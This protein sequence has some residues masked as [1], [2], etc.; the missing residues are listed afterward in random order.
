MKNLCFQDEELFHSLH[1][2]GIKKQ[3]AGEVLL[4]HLEYGKKFKEEIER[5]ALAKTSVR[6]CGGKIGWGLF[7]EEALKNG[8]FVGEYTGNV[9]KNDDHLS[10]NNYLYEYPIPDYIG[11]SHVI[12]A[13][14]GNL[15]RYVNHKT[16]ANLKPV[17]A[18]VEGI[19]HLIL[20]AKQDIGKGEELTYDYGKTYWYVRSPPIEEREEKR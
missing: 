5:G 18:F 20:L 6:W 2:L 13:T 4:E 12:D 7:A 10:V 14:R 19:Y 3:E 1:E 17:Y 9:R 16:H 11:R 8:A 15:I